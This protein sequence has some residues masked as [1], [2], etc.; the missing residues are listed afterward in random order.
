[1][2]LLDW[3]RTKLFLLGIG[4]QLAMALAVITAYSLLVLLVLRAV[5]DADLPT[6]WGAEMSLVNA[7]ILGMLMGLR[8]RSAFDRWWEGRRLWGQ[9]VN[10][11]RNLALKLRHHVPADALLCGRLPETLAGF[12]LALKHHLRGGALLQ[13]IPGF[14][15]DPDT[16]AHVP[17][18]LAGR[19]FERLAA[20]QREGLIDPITALRLDEHAR[21]CMD[22]CGACERIRH[23]PL[24]FSH[25]GLMRLGLLL[26]VIMAP[27]L[28]LADLGAWGIPVIVL[29]CFLLLGIEMVDTA[30]EEPFG[31]DA[32]DLRLGQYCRTI[33][34]SVAEVF[35]PIAWERGQP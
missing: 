31:E 11:T 2:I 19:I 26:N 24:P 22:V 25:K 33:Q 4:K 17:L 8:N 9:L 14:A 7:V 29:A 30:L 6:T 27:W 28:T 32:D 35:K 23:T 21:G 12:P 15:D 1:M 3:V 16:P 20:W 10:D 34:A 5:P 18:Y 13:K